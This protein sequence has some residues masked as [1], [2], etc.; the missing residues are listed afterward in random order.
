MAEETQEEVW[1]HRSKAPLLGRV[2]GGGADRHRNLPMLRFM[3]SQRAGHL[4]R[5]LWSGKKTLAWATGDQVLLVHA[6]GG[7]AL[8]WAKSSR[9][10]NVTWCLLHDLQVEGMDRSSHLRGQREA[11]PTTTGCL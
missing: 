5:R 11:C 4:W 6:M 1:A 8:M 9:V 10:L 2:R 3:G 7:W